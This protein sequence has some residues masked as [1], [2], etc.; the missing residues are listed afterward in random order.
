MDDQGKVLLDL[1]DEAIEDFRVGLLN[2]PEINDLVIRI[3]TEASRY[4]EAL[5]KNLDHSVQLQRID[6]DRSMA[7]K[8]ALLQELWKERFGD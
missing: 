5:G 1:F 2:P 3:R 8:G 6:F 4:S 7:R